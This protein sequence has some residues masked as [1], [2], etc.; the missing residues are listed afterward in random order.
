MQK[1]SVF[2]LSTSLSTGYE[3]GVSLLCH[4]PPVR[5][6]LPTYPPN[7]SISAI[8]AVFAEL[9][10]F[11]NSRISPF[12]G[13]A[14][15][16]YSTPTSQAS[17]HPSRPSKSQRFYNHLSFFVV[18]FKPAKPEASKLFAPTHV[19]RKFEI[20]SVSTCSRICAILRFYRAIVCNTRQLR[21]K[22]LEHSS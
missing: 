1:S 3:P 15:H 5:S 9:S 20:P 17:F 22:S 19:F 6:T 16:S 8:L 18:V 7:S 14:E 10:S 4:T 11:T 2:V 12:K 21:F 13:S